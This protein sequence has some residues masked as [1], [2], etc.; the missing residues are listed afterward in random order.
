VN[1]IISPYS[2]PYN[3][4]GT[5]NYQSEYRI[6]CRPGFFSLNEGTFLLVFQGNLYGY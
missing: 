3:I 6:S 2:D 1:V 4:L 5:N